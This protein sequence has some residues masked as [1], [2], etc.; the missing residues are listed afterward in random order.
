MKKYY[1]E[2]MKNKA[3]VNRGSFLKMETCVGKG[4]NPRLSID[5]ENKSHLFKIGT[6][7]E[8]ETLPVGN[9]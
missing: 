4:Y 2:I 6:M 3:L 7:R 9:E 8:E 1:I 5:N